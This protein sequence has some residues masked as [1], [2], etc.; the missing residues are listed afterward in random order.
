MGFKI[1]GIGARAHAIRVG[2]S[3]PSHDPIMGGRGS[4]TKFSYIYDPNQQLL[5]ALLDFFKE[6]DHLSFLKATCS[7]IP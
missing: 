2:P 6:K 7:Q 4:P 5:L 3:Q 1:K